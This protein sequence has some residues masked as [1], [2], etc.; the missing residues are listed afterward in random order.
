MSAADDELDRLGKSV[1][2]ALPELSAEALERQRARV[3]DGLSQDRRAGSPVRR[4]GAAAAAVAAAIALAWTIVPRRGGDAPAKLGT[5]VA[6][7]ELP[8]PVIPREERPDTQPG[9]LGP[10]AE[11]AGASESDT[12][13]LESGRMNVEPGASRRVVA[14]PYTVTAG[15]E[16][17]FELTWDAE[18]EA[19][20]VEVEHGEV[21]VTRAK[22]HHVIVAGDVV[23]STATEFVVTRMPTAR[24]ADAAD[25]ARSAS[26]PASP[27]V[28]A[29]KRGEYR[30]ALELAKAAGALESVRTLGRQELK[31]LADTTRLGG[32]P[33]RSEA[34]LLE[35]RKRFPRSTDAKRAAFYL[36]RAS[37]TADAHDDA[38]RWYRT[39]LGT[40]PKGSFAAQA[41]GRLLR[42]LSQ[43]GSRADAAAAARDYLAHHPEGAYA[44][45]ASRLA[46]P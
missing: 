43:H 23:H 34:I 22:S 10:S 5:L 3:V 26:P 12:V 8:S 11:E 9:S 32:A 38:I 36:G 24:R 40:S 37:E 46:K 25:D 30:R 20:S 19:F 18:A 39:Y 13:V 27:W 35:L 41:R 1:G 6:V 45:L 4:W 17:G 28:R 2:A 33:R 7:P 15:P 44:S 21:A 29:A 42:V 14:G 16:A 31:L